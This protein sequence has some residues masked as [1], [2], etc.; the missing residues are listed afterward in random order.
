MTPARYEMSIGGASVPA[1]SGRTFASLNPY[2]G[3]AWAEVPDGDA[4]DVDCAVAAARAALEGE[5]G[6]IGPTSRGRL[7]RRLGDVLADNAERLAEIE[8]RDN[9]KLL[10]E[11]AA[12]MHQMPEWFHYFAG[13]ADK[14]EGTTI[15]SE[16]PNFFIY[17]RPEP[18]GVVGA[19]VPWNSPLMLSAWKLAPALATGCTFV[20][21]PSEHTPVSAIEL[22]GCVAEAGIPAGVFNVVTGNGP[23]VGRA[24]SE[25]PGVDKIAFTGS[26]ETGIAVARTAVVNMTRLS[27][28]LGGKSAQL[29]FADA[30]L[31][32]AANGVIAGVFAATGQTCMAGSR[33][34]VE[35]SIHDELV[36][37]IAARARTIELGDPALPE[38]E[39]GPVANHAQLRRVLDLIESVPAEG[40]AFAC[41]GGR[42]EELGGLFVEPTI[43]TGVRP[44]MRLAREEVFGPVL[45]VTAFE[46]DEEA[47]RLANDSRYGLAA[48]VWTKDIHRAHRVAHA[49]R[50]G[51]VYVNSYRLAAPNV[52][53]G[54]MK[55]SGWG[56]ESGLNAVREYCET[57]AVWVELTGG[58]RDPFTVG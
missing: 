19:I 28:E 48:G 58:T 37:R 20:L 55:M 6:A 2:T 49:L 30:D 9:G 16:Q 13:L 23:E 18:V 45:A 27:L 57:K 42:S 41:G 8:T 25:H 38:T 22:A 17:T 15:P 7:L 12:Q 10:R 24:L 14:L 51:T 35:R 34:L 40:G 32:A 43:A 11:M 29:V 26:T 5:W 52:P 33:L 46:G 56:R 36:A 1:L 21:K 47:I 39:M 50:A 3:Q 31:A 44:D 4:A 54:G 53:F